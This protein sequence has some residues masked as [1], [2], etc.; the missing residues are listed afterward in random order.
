MPPPWLA[1][2][3]GVTVTRVRGLF[4]SQAA[5]VEFCLTTHCTDYHG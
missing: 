1:A 2:G 4:C 3:P 5:G